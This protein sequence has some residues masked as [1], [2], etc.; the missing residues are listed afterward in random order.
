M[1][2][3]AAILVVFALAIAWRRR[4]PRACPAMFSFLLDTPLRDVGLAR[5]DLTRRLTLEPGMRVLEIGPGGGFYTEAI[6]AEHGTVRLV[7]LDLQLAMLHK[8]R[9]RLGPRAPQ[10]VCAS[11]SAIPFRDQSFERIF[12]VSVLGEVSDRANALRECARL[13]SQ[14]GKLVIAEALPDPDYIRPSVLVRDASD[15]GL[16]PVDR[17]GG[18]ASYM[19][20]FGRRPLA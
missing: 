6:V 13:L 18:W 19:Q 15:A 8:V 17:V 7:C 20:R 12:M 3:L 1:L 11:A 9:R 5:T 2:V 14:D 4:H 16:A 10:V